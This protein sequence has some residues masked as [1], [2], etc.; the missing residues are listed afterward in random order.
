MTKITFSRK[1]FEK[2]IKIT[3]EI[4][5]KINLFGAPID[6]LTDDEIEIEVNPNRPDL[7]S[8]YTYLRAIKSFIGK[9]KGLK[10]YNLHKPDK[11]FKII[12]DKS[13]KE[14]RPYTSCAIV[15]N[16]SLTEEKIKDII[17][18]QEKLAFT[19]GR[20]RKKMAIGIYP[21]DK[22]NLPITYTAKEPK[23][24]KYQPLGV[25][26][27]LTANE[28][29][30]VHPAGRKYAH[31]LNGAKKYPVFI[32]AKKQVLSMPPIINSEH[33][34]RIN[35]ETKEV[36]IECSGLEKS[37]L[38]KTL[39]IMT[40]AL[41]EMGGKI[42]QMEI[43]GYE[44]CITPNF[45]TEKIKISLDN[46]NNLLGLSLT[47]S[48]LVKLLKK[49]G[50]NYSKGKV[51]IAPWRTDILH[52]VDL[53]EDVAIA[54]G[55][56]NFAPEI[57]NISTTGEESKESIIKRKISEIL[58]GL[59]MLE[60]SSYHLINQEEANIYDPKELLKLEDSK[61][62]YKYLRPNLFIPSLRILSE[63]KDAE[64]P[65]RIFEIGAVFSK[66]SGKE[67][68]IDEKNN[69][70]FS[71]TPANATECK[72]HIDYLFKSLGIKYTIKEATSD[73][74][75]DGRTAEIILNDKVIGYFGEVHPLTL[76]KAGIKTPVAV[77]EIS[78]EE[79]F[80]IIN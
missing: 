55:Y 5:E 4:E 40:S 6:S 32:D 45:V 65:Q 30:L 71:L 24:I 3:K 44:N 8:L 47:E 16:L 12:V 33:T 20:N 77:A 64:Y 9:E 39:I 23:E 51:E 61:T 46:T 11:E 66:N 72:Q 68:H 1:E 54:Y 57:P 50:H 42:H 27:E 31:L 2:E 73:N 43:K 21:L 41:A 79:I 13:V 58:I 18:M 35:I 22:I 7:L 69:I 60:I 19:L 74:L 52:E 38:E 49:M 78:L 36:F 34:G 29:L 53:I 56:N 67:T 10:K 28:I 76:K 62:E 25:S 70:I 75:I 80:K 26:Q 37:V 15:K 14:I 48:E 17:N 63:N 59:G